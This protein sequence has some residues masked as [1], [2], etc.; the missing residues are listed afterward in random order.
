V[1]KW[2]GNS[3]HGG[4]FN[5]VWLQRVLA[6]YATSCTKVYGRSLFNA[7]G[8]IVGFTR[9]DCAA[10]RCRTPFSRLCWKKSTS[11]YDLARRFDKSIGYF[12]H[13]THQQIYRELARMEAAG[14]I[15]AYVP[16]D[17]GN[18]RKKHYRVLDAGRTELARWAQDSADPMDLRDAFTVKLRADA[19][20]G[21]V[22][23]VPELQRHLTLHEERLAQ[24]QRFEARDFARAQPLTRAQTI[25]HMILKKG[26]LYEEGE[27][28][29]GREML[30][31]LTAPPAATGTPED[32]PPVTPAPTGGNADR[33]ML[34]AATFKQKWA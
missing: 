34:A 26:M 15:E 18:T 3:G 11:G 24:Y 1:R 17:A 27:I 5:L 10:C 32:N 28:A 22:D 16:P 20:L 8:C 6:R 12:W 31:L 7:T 25:Q 33:L 21:E 14:W 30:A 19:V 9:L 23:L 2:R 29:W 13:A 4:S